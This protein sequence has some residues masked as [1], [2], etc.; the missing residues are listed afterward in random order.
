MVASICVEI[1]AQAG[2][3]ETIREA[4]SCFV[5]IHKG[6]FLATWIAWLN[7]GSI[8]TYKST[9]LGTIEDVGGNFT[10]W[11]VT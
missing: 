9:L 6:V 8:K 11:G 5:V 3:T 4:I 2:T 10:Q 7:L 1:T